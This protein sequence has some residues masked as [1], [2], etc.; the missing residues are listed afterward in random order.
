MTLSFS[1]GYYATL[2][3]QSNKPFWI[4]PD[5]RHSYA[6][7]VAQIQIWCA[8][9]DLASA[10]TGDR[11]VIA[12]E[13][14][15]TATTAFM[16]AVLDGKVPL[17]LSP[18]AGDARLTAIV[19]R[20]GPAITLADPDRAGEEWA[21]G[22]I[23]CGS[24]EASRAAADIN[25]EQM[26]LPRLLETATLRAPSCTAQNSDTAYL[27][28]TSGT[29]Q[30][31]KGAILSHG[32][33]AQ[34]LSDIARVFNLTPEARLFN[35][36]V[37][38]HTDGLIQG[39]LLCGFVGA[40]LIRPQPFALTRLE[41]DL[42]FSEREAATHMISVPL[43]YSTMVKHAARDD[44]FDRPDFQG[45][46]STAARLDAQVWQMIEDRFGVNVI[47]EY[48]MTETVAASH[49]AGPHP[50][51]GAKFTIGK[52]VGC[53]AS[54]RTPEG[55][56][57]APDEAGEL[58]VRGPIVFQGYLGNPERTAEVLQDG[59]LRTG[60]LVRC[61]AQGSYRIVG[62]LNTTI[63]SGGFRI[64]PEEI[65]EVL[66]LCPAVEEAQTVGLDHHEFG[67]IAVSAVVATDRDDQAL[68]AAC[69]DKLE[70]WKQPRKIIFVE[71]IPRTGSGKAEIEML[72]DILRDKLEIR[73]DPTE[74]VHRNVIRLAALVFN[75]DEAAVVLDH[76]PDEIEAW[77]SFTHMT[78]AI[79]AEKLFKFK[80]K[81]N[82]ILEI[83]TLNNL[84]DIV[85]SH[86]N[87][88]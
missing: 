5:C 46:L 20:T 34:Q 4:T 28:F 33:L 55:R 26:A 18:E 60:D 62:R 25:L 10:K 24:D 58:W 41:K 27:L 22:A 71:S 9:F 1:Q 15:W 12:I 70:P 75:L 21:Y 8:I 45:L 31:P 19:E 65:D 2:T 53:E 17:V 37:L 79:E 76:G 68:Y 16:A 32:N 29:T 87:P 73:L 50:E 85:L 44:Y 64:Q 35:G 7:L 49:F 39:P 67:T 42:E 13:D 43:V 83:D 40:T 69:R 6:D 54:I 63:N 38:Y 51:M 84:A 11:I 80:L 61:D 57:A 30:A 47:N 56:I 66:I 14:D 81:S 78:L 48:G 72:K 88:N 23:I 59:W 74:E 3:A 36:L 52:P 82:E 77:D 86:Q